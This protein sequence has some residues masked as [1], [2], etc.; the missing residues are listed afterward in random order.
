VPVPPA[1]PVKAEA[2][3]GVVLERYT[4]ALQQ[5]DLSALK[6]VWPGLSGAQQTAIESDF[7][8][9]R[10]ISVQFVSPKIDVSGST[11][12]VTG[13]RRYG[14]QTRDG[15]RLHTETTTTLVLRQ[16]ANGWHI[17]SVRH[18]AR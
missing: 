1:S 17:E 15:Q 9:A 4:N 11:A 7:N 12:T 10:S 6:A 14:M 3:I 2:A 16:G 5:R 13:V 8:L 18:Q